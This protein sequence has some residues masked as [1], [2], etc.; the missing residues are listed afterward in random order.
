M[1]DELKLIVPY[2]SDNAEIFNYAIGRFGEM[3]TGVLKWIAHMQNVI[4]GV[5][6]ELRD[7]AREGRTIDLAQAARIDKLFADGVQRFRPV[8]WWQLW[9]GI[10]DPRAGVRSVGLC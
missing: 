9:Q 6:A 10:W 5:A 2:T 4:A 8:R 7:V 3:H 1:N